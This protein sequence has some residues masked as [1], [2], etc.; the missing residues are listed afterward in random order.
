[1]AIPVLLGEPKRGETLRNKLDVRLQSSPSKHGL[2]RYYPETAAG[3]GCVTL[4]LSP[5]KKGRITVITRLQENNQYRSVSAVLNQT[6]DESEGDT[7]QH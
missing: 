3:H 7:N 2:G 6:E 4:L 1:M 5:L